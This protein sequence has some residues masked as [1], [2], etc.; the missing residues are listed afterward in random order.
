MAPLPAAG[1]HVVRGPGGRIRHG[2]R[3]ADGPPADVPVRQA[4][5]AFTTLALR[6]GDGQNLFAESSEEG[7]IRRAV[8]NRLQ[9]RPAKDAPPAWADTA[10]DLL[11]RPV[12]PFAK[13]RQTH[14]GPM[15]GVATAGVLLLVDSWPGARHDSQTRPRSK[16]PLPSAG[17]N[18][19]RPPRSE[20]PTAQ[21]ECSTT[22]WQV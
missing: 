16:P 17:Q 3:P 13:K 10:D 12:S 5:V 14:L 20:C 11:L 15:I 7:G 2:R 22:D 18:E 4:F 1:D 21:G 8:A 19:E 9:P 6:S